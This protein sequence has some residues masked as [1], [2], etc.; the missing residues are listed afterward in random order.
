[1]EKVSVK[2]DLNKNSIIWD[3]GGGC[4]SIAIECSAIARNGK[5]FCIEKSLKTVL[6]TKRRDG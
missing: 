2:L 3:I 4:G 6:K 5:I 1:M